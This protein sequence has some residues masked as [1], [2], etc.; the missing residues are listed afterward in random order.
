MPLALINIVLPQHLSGIVQLSPTRS[1][2][3]AA[4]LHADTLPRV[5]GMK[6]N[7]QNPPLE[8]FPPYPNP[9]LPLRKHTDAQQG[10]TVMRTRNEEPP[11]ASWPSHTP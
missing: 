5:P 2:A 10:D 9:H 6:G 8:Q 4:A 1:R 11:F 3:A 7:R